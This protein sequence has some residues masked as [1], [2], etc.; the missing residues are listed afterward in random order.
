MNTKYFSTEDHHVARYTVGGESLSGAQ[1]LRDGV[2]EPT[3][4][5]ELAFN[6]NPI[7]EEEGLKQIAKEMKEAAQ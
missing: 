3:T 2:W 7:S 6:A 5:A 1:V 4:P